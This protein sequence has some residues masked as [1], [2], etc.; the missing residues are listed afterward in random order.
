MGTTESI[1]LSDYKCPTLRTLPNT[2]SNYMLLV[3]RTQIILIAADRISNQDIT[4]KLSISRP[5]V[6]LWRQRF[7]ALILPSLKKDVPCLGHIPKISQQKIKSMVEIPQNTTPHNS[8]HWRTRMMAKSQ[9]LSEATIRRILKK[10]KLKSH[11]TKKFKL[12]TDKH[13]C[14]KLCDIDGLLLN[15]LDKSLVLCI[16]EKP[17]NPGS[18]AY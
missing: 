8:T 18:V 16:D 7:L 5:T 3:Q 6:Q 9:G 4:Q 10:S 13:S 14:E 12:G 15:P 1:I 11:N 2:R 17:P